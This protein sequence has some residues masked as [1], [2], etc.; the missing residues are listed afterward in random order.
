MFDLYAYVL[1]AHRYVVWYGWF[2]EGRSS[3]VYD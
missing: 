3:Y 2:K 1:F